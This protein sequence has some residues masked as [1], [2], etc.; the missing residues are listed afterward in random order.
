MKK[1]LSLFMLSF[2]AFFATAQS[3]EVTTVLGENF[4]AFTEGT[5]ATPGTTDISNYSSGKLK[6]TLTGWSGRKVYEA[7]GKL[8]VD[9]G[10]NL[11]TPKMDLTAN[12]GIYRL[13]LRLRA[14]SVALV[15]IYVGYSKKQSLQIMDSEWHDYQF[16]LEGGRS[17]DFI[18][19]Q[20]GF[21]G[22][23]Y[24][25][26]IAIEQ[27]PTFVPV[28]EAMQPVVADGTKFNANWTSVASATSYLLDVYTKNQ[29]GT[30]EYFWQDKEIA[31]STRSIQATEVSG[32][33][34]TKT[35]FYTVRAKVGDNVSDFSNEIEVVKVIYGELPAPV[36]QNASDI[37]TTTF[38]AHFTESENAEK[39]EVNLFK[40]TK[41]EEAGIYPII[42][43]NWDKIT[44]GNIATGGTLADNLKE[45]LD[46]Y[47]T[48][49]GWY[50]YSHRFA[51]GYIGVDRD[52]YIVTPEIDLSAD[53]GKGKLKMRIA[54]LNRGSEV[55]SDSCMVYVYDLNKQDEDPAM[56][57]VY[58]ANGFKDVELDFTTGSTRSKILISYSS[59]DWDRSLWFDSITIEQ[60]LPKDFVKYTP[61][62]KFET[63]ETTVNITVPEAMTDKLEYAYDV[64]AFA[65]TVDSYEREIYWISSAPSNRIPVKY[66]SAVQDLKANQVI[67]THYYNVQGMQSTNPFQGVNIVI[68]RMSDG[69]TRTSKVIK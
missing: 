17:T 43:E 8:Y 31:P 4:D 51:N 68:Q 21:V 5:E 9:A 44:T 13:F 28:P 11:Q 19:I 6:N 61:A 12:G 1:F 65:R 42:S 2:M 69:S 18:K 10:G 30:K 53:Q 41:I 20:P 37:T 40:A 57:P 26:S 36:A 16:I 64:T 3:A 46:P 60:N 56:I 33:D 59:E 55:E 58:L 22:E 67:S 54:V 29:D 39:Y 7:G 25:D 27:S 24:I 32:L 15:D 52:G 23:Y 45:Y 38:K 34:N 49:P 62:G 47:T 50:A 35:Y 66:E 48:T 63:T 14:K